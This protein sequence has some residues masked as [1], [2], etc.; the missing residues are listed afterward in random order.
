[1]YADSKVVYLPFSGK[2][3]KEVLVERKPLATLVVRKLYPDRSLCE[4]ITPGKIEEIRAGQTV[5]EVKPKFERTTNVT[6]FIEFLK[7]EPETLFCGQAGRVSCKVTDANDKRHLYAWSASGGLMYPTVGVCG[8]AHWLAPSEPGKYTVSVTVS[9]RYGAS[10]VKKI[11]VDVKPFPST[12]AFSPDALFG[13][14]HPLFLE[15]RDL[16]FDEKGRMVILDGKERKLILYDFDN[17]PLFK[18]SSYVEQMDYLRLHI[19]G[20]K[21]FLTEANSCSIHIWSSLEEVFKSKPEVVIGEKGSGN[22]C[23]SSPPLVRIHPSNGRLYALDTRLGCIQV[24]EPDGRFLYSFGRLGNSPESFRQPVAMEFS[25]EEQLLVL[26]ATRK[27]ILLFK[28]D[29]FAGTFPLIEPL[30][31]PLD[32]RVDYF[33]SR[34]IV[35]ESAQI[36][37]FDRQGKVVSRFGTAGLLERLD[38]PHSLFLNPNGTLYVSCKKG[39]LLKRYE[40]NGTFGGVTGEKILGEQTLYP[41]T[42]FAVSKSGEI[43]LLLEGNRIAKL[44][45]DGFVVALFGGY[46]EVKGSLLK[47][48][49]MGVDNDG[50]LYVADKKLLSITKF[51]PKGEFLI[52]IKGGTERQERI[53]NIVD[54]KV[55]GRSI[56]LLQSRE[57]YAVLV[58]DADGKIVSHYPS[59]ESRISY[60]WRIAVDSSNKTYIYTEAGKIE[61]FDVSGQRRMSISDIL[62][63]LNDL[64]ILPSGEILAVA[65]NS[66]LFKITP[67]PNLKS[68]MTSLKLIRYP[69]RVESDSFGRLYVLDENGSIILRLRNR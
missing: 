38:E 40:Q 64:I 48:V 34:L 26:D 36:S 15:V 52:S 31:A 27:D 55:I 39:S 62:F 46:G 67:G 63:S 35:L 66:F 6:P 29:R 30:S 12:V 57:T 51:S 60:P 18:T 59:S 1:V 9:D 23:F 25:P 47:P 16:S 13:Y 54:M 14:A 37:V 22:G 2:E 28:D 33:T 32:M 44:T 42:D 58:F 20:G 68:R 5:V 24:F 41:A 7:V 49:A 8:E 61:C 17:Q 19:A 50:N 11:T 10:A 21:Y 53:D 43:F 65:D 56:Y 4:L 3:E 45:E 69:S